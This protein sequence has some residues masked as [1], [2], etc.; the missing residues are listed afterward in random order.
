MTGAEK[1]TSER[2]EELRQE[3][4]SD[5]AKG[6]TKWLWA[7]ASKR[8]YLEAKEALEKQHQPELGFET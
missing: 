1:I 2:V 8:L 5:R 4:L 6:G 7:R 3:W